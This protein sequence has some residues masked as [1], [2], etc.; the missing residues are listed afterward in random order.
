[1]SNK[2]NERH[3]DEEFLNNL[4]TTDN[5]P[6]ASDIGAVSINELAAQ[7]SSLIEQGVIEVGEKAYTPSSTLLKTVLNSEKINTSNPYDGIKYIGKWIPE[8]SGA[9]KVLFSLKNSDY[10]SLGIACTLSEFDSNTSSTAS[11]FCAKLENASL[12]ANVT[13]FNTIENKMPSCISNSISYANYYIILKVQ[14]G[15]PVYFGIKAASSNSN[16]KS[17]CN[18]IAIYA[19]EV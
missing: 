7:I 18:R 17:Y 12:D 14:K 11:R 19:D 10:E 3:L 2:I 8:Y 9:V 4:Y 13:G 1:M 6:T 16:S 5:P 15:V